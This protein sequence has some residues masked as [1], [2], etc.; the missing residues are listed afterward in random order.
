MK[1]QAAFARHPSRVVTALSVSPNAED[2]IGLEAIFSHSNW[3]LFQADE[4]ARA[5]SM[6]REHGIGV[7][8]C[9]RDLAPGNWTDLILALGRLSPA[10]PPVIVTSR[11]ADDALWSEA[12][13]RGAY[14]VLA[15]PYRRDDVVRSVRQAWM[16]W[17]REEEAASAVPRVLGAAS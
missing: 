14:D 15:K 17:I 16:H 10:P 6:I 11:S 8:F 12:L 7:V 9:E 5:A 13:N 2:H 3:A 4:P 1:K